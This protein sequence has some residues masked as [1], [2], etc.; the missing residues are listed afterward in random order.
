MTDYTIARYEYNLGGGKE[1][2]TSTPWSGSIPT[3][4]P[5][6]WPRCTAWPSATRSL[7]RHVRPAGAEPVRHAPT[8]GGAIGPRRRPDRATLPP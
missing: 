4:R 1:R 7:Q 8:L 3:A 5:P 2:M 6:A